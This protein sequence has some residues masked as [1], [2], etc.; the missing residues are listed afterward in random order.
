MSTARDR[1][2][3]PIPDFDH[4]PEGALAHHIRSLSEEE[5]VRRV[6]EYERDHANRLA[7]TLVLERRISALRAGEATQ[8]A[9]DPAAAQPGQPPSPAAVSP[10]SETGLAGIK[11]PPGHGEVDQTPNRETRAS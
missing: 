4:L 6:L 2:E 10:D 5:D 9:G 1:T 8:S 7:M 3:L 11:Q